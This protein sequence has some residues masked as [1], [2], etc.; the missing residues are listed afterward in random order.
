MRQLTQVT[1]P[2]CK[3]PFQAEVEQILDVS[4]DP[5]VKSRLLSGSLNLIQCPACG[6]QGQLNLPLVYHDAEKELML[7]YAPVDLSVSKN[8]QEMM[9]GRLIK[10]IVDQLPAEKRKGYLLQPKSVLTLQGLAENILEADG[11]T[12]EEL[13]S[14]RAKM[15]LFEDL[16]RT[17]EEQIDAFVKDHDEQI[18]AAFMQLASLTIQATADPQAQQ[19]LAVRLEKVIELST[20]GQALTEQREE[21]DKASQSLQELG[22]KITR[23]AILDLLIEAPNDLRVTALVNYTR[24][25]LDY[26]FFQ[27]LTDRIEASE[28]A[29][30]ETLTVLRKKIL[31]ITEEIDKAQ[32]ERIQQTAGLIQHLVESED[33]D[34][35]LERS[36][37]LIDDVFLGVLRSLL[38]AASRQKDEDQFRKL[39]RIENRIAELIKQSLPR[40]LQLAQELLP[41]KDLASALQLIDDN[42]ADVDQDLLNGL[43][44]A[45]QRYQ[46]ADRAEEAERIQAIYNHALK[47]SMKA[48]M[49]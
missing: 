18:D 19:A 31:E 44:S 33:L 4:Q 21:I 43:L 28:G 14:Q 7:T 29:E 46:E 16:L 10:Q 20:F 3:T 27:L 48:K 22:E 34:V 37:P 6:F 25:G 24:A 38:E 30:R 39:E 5:G 15:K 36:M 2:N 45:L 11:I 9:I 32:E 13:E 26:T 49:H 42:S 47:T 41:M 12:K 23:E 8:E 35:E 1:C 40:G 17:P